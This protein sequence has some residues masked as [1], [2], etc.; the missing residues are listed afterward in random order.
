LFYPFFFLDIFFIYISNAI[1]KIPYTLSPFF[2]YIPQSRCPCALLLPSPL[3]PPVFPIFPRS[4]THFFSSRKEQV[5]KRQQP[6]VTKQ[7]TIRLGISPHIK[8]E[9]GN[10]IGE[11]E[12]QEQAKKSGM[13]GLVLLEV[14]QKQQANSFNL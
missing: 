6:K 11:K 4:I 3:P 8:A 14:S 13:D 2:W 7:D 10:P 12:S 9:Q 1:P 5:S